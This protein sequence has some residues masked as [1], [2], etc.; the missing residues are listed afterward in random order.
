MLLLVKFICHKF[1]HYVFAELPVLVCF[2]CQYQIPLR[3]S[4]QECCQQPWPVLP[5]SYDRTVLR[6]LAAE[7]QV[8]QG[9]IRAWF[10]LIIIALT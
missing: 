1:S 3:V 9:N 2:S 10:N 8:I 4:S 5:T 7:A 6:S